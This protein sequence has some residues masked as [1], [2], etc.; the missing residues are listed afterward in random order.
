MKLFFLSA[1]AT[2]S[3]LGLFAQSQTGTT[4]FNKSPQPAVIYNLPYSAEAVANG[5]ENK[6][7]TYGKPKKVKG[8]LM[9]KNILV[10]EISKNP[11]T[12]YF[13]AE[14][15]SNK[16][17]ANAVLTMMISNEFDRF[18]AVEDNKELFESA[19]SFLNGFELSVVAAN[20]ELKIKDQ[21]ESVKKSDKKLKNLRDDGI[22]YEKQRKKLEDK[23]SQNTLDITAQ[24]QELNKQKEQLDGLIKQRK[25]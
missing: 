9:Y 4:T 20:L 21:D 6:M 7:N 10:T 13:N 16:D 14:K 15:K 17:D 23:I 2:I 1:I 25:N 8:F 5:V 22:D 11:V 3:T 18:Y 12:I 24:E 19:K